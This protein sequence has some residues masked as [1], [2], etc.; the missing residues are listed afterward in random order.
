MF[1]EISRLI[2]RNGVKPTLVGSYTC[3]DAVFTL[4]LEMVAIYHNFLSFT[5]T[6]IR[7][8]QTFMSSASTNGNLPARLLDNVRH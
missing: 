7:Q 1:L 2:H 4:V 5:F 6:V 8:F 3:I